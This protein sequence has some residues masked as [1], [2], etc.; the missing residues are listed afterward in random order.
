I[1]ATKITKNPLVIPFEIC[2]V[3]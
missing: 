1:L 2:V 3:E